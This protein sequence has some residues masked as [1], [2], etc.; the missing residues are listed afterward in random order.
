MPAARAASCRRAA[1]SPMLMPAPYAEAP[2]N[3]VPLAHGSF[4]PATAANPA[5]L[6][7]DGE[8]LHRLAGEVGYDLEVLVEM[9]D[10]EPGQFGCRRDD[11]VGY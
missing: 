11:Q 6:S 4:P 8:A 9:Q 1:P 3:T 7:A 2:D 10:V 5:Q